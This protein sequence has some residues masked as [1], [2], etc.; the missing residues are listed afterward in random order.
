MLSLRFNNV[1]NLV[2]GQLNVE[3]IK[4]QLLRTRDCMTA[5]ANRN[6]HNVSALVLYDGDGSTGPQMLARPPQI[7]G[8][9]NFFLET[10]KMIKLNGPNAG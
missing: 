7:S 1:V 6:A 9:L 4:L 10:E 3:K 8:Q 5:D 2:A